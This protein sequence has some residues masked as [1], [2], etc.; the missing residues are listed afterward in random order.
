M[1][2]AAEHRMSLVE[3]VEKLIFQSVE[4]PVGFE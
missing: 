4:Q 2:D 1:L 3:L